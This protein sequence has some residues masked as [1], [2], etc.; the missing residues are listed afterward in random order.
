MRS[1][2]G[3]CRRPRRTT[4]TGRLP[5]PRASSRTRGTSSSRTA[6]GPRR[7][8]QP[9]TRMTKCSTA[10]ERSSSSRSS[11]SSGSTSRPRLPTSATPGLALATPTQPLLVAMRCTAVGPP[12]R[13]SGPR[14][15]PARLREASY[16]ARTSEATGPAGPRSALATITSFEWQVTLRTTGSWPQGSRAARRAHS[17]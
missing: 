7:Q 12:E 4:G 15:V 10:T 13:A 16:P 9:T 5:R 6:T 2:T 17:S 8:A 1:S 14:V 11:Q 3:V